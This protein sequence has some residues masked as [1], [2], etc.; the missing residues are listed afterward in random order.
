M[1][2]LSDDFT[3][4][5][6]AK[7]LLKFMVPILGALVLQAMYG[8]V[9]LLVVGQ[10]GT[11]AGIS[12]VSTGSNI[13][14]LA[15]FIITGLTMGVTVLISRYLGEQSPERIG[16]VIG[17]AIAF[18]F[19]LTVMMMALLLV[20]APG[21]A[22]ALN[23]PEEAYGLTVEY[24]R[25][26]GAGLVFVVAY[27]VISG[28]F[29]G[30]GN[31]RLPLIF[32]S[33][34]CVVNIAGDLLFVAVF[35]MDVAGA[36]F[37]TILAQLVSVVLSLVIIKRQELPFSVSWADIGFNPEIKNFL[38]LGFPIALQDMLVNISFLIL[39]AIVN[40]IGLEASSGYGIAQKVTAFVM[41][42]P[43]ALMQSMS[44]FVA[45]NVGAGKEERAKKAMVTGMVIGACIGVFIFAFSFFGGNLPSA[46]FTSDPAYIARSAE[47]LKGFSPEAIL[48]CLVF[49]Y[50]GYFNGHGK[51][52]PVMVQG[53]TS[54]FLIRVPLSYL[55]SIQP[56][57]NLVTIGAAVPITSVYGIL[58]FTVCYVA[59][60]QKMKVGAAFS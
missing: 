22:R 18:F 21:F 12:A 17:G 10:F 3:Q 40:G 38:K 41:L 11:S 57:A 26:C 15:T 52:M 27:N 42:I 56:G 33:I 47:Y 45:Q 36:A 29:R 31:S 37:A 34:A 20:F 54:S 25:I 48:T 9:D 32:V 55:F 53:I 59:F 19:L 46:L 50:I 13:I 2:K 60:Q 43:S 23:A 16:K 5:S 8:A 14:N 35:Q 58:F 44:A 4:G 30:L 51:T 6:I 39:C 28:I 7:K 49:S 24:V 1:N